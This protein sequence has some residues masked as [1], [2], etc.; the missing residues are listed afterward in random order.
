MDGWNRELE[1]EGRMLESIVALLISF[2]CLAD[3][4]SSLPVAARLKLLGFLTL[5]EAEV[6][7][8]VLGL[9]PCA[10]GEATEP[11]FDA[12]RAQRLAASFRALAWVL[13]TLLAEA[14]RLAR[15]A[16]AALSSP[17]CGGSEGQPC[18]AWWRGR[19]AERDHAQAAPLDTS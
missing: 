12:D 19:T 18:A 3:R 1:R 13:M 2:A 16:G 15:A 10:S 6:R 7:N 11:S 8:F 17:A 4:A 5:G 9:M 14:R